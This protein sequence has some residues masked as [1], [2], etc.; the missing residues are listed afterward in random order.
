M[1]VKIYMARVLETQN[2]TARS[3]GWNAIGSVGYVCRGDDGRNNIDTRRKR[4]D[5]KHKTR[6]PRDFISS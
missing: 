6:Q 2:R 4:S 1:P 3:R 5:L